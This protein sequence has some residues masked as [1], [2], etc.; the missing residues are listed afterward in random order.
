MSNL[1]V[2]RVVPQTAVDPDTFTGYLNGSGLGP[3]QITAYDL[4][5]DSPT[6]GQSRNPKG[7]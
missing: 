6:A 7:S 5:F 3:L 4:S 1:L 2:I